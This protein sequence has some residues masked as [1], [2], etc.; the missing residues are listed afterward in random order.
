[1]E[2]Q[3]IAIS[4]G[5]TFRHTYS[6]PFFMALQNMAISW[7][8]MPRKTRR[9]LDY[10]TF[11]GGQEVKKISDRG[12]RHGRPS[13][14]NIGIDFEDQA[15]LGLWGNAPHRKRGGAF[16]AKTRRTMSYCLL[17]VLLIFSGVSGASDSRGGRQAFAFIIE[18]AKPC[19][20]DHRCL[21]PLTQGENE[22]HR[23][24]QERKTLP[25]P[26]VVSS[27]SAN[28]GGLLDSVGTGSCRRIISCCQ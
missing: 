26:S 20:V 16:S 8:R 14:K 18:R 23:S 17:I 13:I 15:R 28:K 25:R 24:V 9:L 10:S 27:A 2:F 21:M 6:T 1:M 22:R 7:R 12:R 11:K 3:E 4:T 19:C 5:K